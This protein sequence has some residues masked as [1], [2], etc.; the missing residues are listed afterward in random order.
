M[1]TRSGLRMVLNREN[2]LS[3]VL[4]AFDRSIVQVHVGDLEV[5]SPRNLGF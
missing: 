5:W 3:P 1:R 2:G 4:E